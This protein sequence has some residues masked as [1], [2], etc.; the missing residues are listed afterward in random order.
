[1]NTNEHTQ[2]QLAISDANNSTARGRK[3]DHRFD[4]LWHFYFD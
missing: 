1:M 3:G 4:V 2:W